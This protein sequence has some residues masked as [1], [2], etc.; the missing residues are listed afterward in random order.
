MLTKELTNSAGSIATQNEGG[1]HGHV[2]M[3]IDK[4]EYITFSKNGARFVVPTNPGPYPTTLDADKVIHER[5]NAEHKAECIEYETYLGIKNY[6]CRMIVKSLDQEWL[7]EVKSET[8]GF[9]H[10]SLS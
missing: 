7:A 4:A 9:N 10:L 6:I 3:V 1:E 2:G 8:M 5:Q